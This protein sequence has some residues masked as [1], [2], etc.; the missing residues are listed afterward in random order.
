MIYDKSLRL[1]LWSVS[2]LEDSE[3]NVETDGCPQPQPPRI[4]K[5]VTGDRSKKGEKISSTGTSDPDGACSSHADFGRITNL[6][7]EDTYN[8]MSFVWIC[9]YV[10]AIPV[11]VSPMT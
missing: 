1:P 2:Q 10:W 3:D 8:I 7:A 5:L 9:H 6:M 4:D 11:K